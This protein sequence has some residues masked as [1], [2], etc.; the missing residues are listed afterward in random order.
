MIES[1]DQSLEPY[2][3]L[4]SDTNDDFDSFVVVSEGTAPEGEWGLVNVDLKEYDGKE[5]YVAIQYVGQRFKNVC[6]MVDDI[7]VKGDGLGVANV[8]AEDVYMR[9]N[10]TEATITVNANE[11]IQ[12]VELFNLQ[13]QV[14][15]AADANMTTL[16]RFSVADCPAGVY[17]CKVYTATGTA[18]QKFVVR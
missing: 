9:Y 2:R 10:A 18:A 12:R 4:V 7:E 16:Y 5:I 3:V 11:A 13:G 17:I 1:M 8:N 14:V 6:L 15:Y